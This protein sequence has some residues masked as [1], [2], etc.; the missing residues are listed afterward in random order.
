MELLVR[1]REVEQWRSLPVVILS[2]FGDFVNR[3]VTERLGVAAILSKPLSDLEQ[4]VTAVQRILGSEA[5]P[6]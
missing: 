6:S 1:I 5:A 4:I 3:D 2:G